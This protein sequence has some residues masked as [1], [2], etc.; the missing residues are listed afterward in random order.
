MGV[1]IMIPYIGILIALSMAGFSYILEDYTSFIPFLIISLLL[2]NCIS[3]SIK[4]FV[5]KIF[6]KKYIG[7]I[8]KAEMVIGRGENTYFLFIEFYKNKKKLIR[9]TSGYMGNPNQYLQ[10]KNCHVYEILGM[11]IENDLNTRTKFPD[12]TDDYL[13]IKIEP[14]KMFMPKGNKYV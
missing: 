4:K 2:L 1:A 3:Y 8:V 10:N 9:R 11:F 7:K 6:G 13:D 12:S 5:F 14:H